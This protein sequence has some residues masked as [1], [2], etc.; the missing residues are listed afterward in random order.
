MSVD[1]DKE[2][3]EAAEERIKEQVKKSGV[4][5]C[6]GDQLT[7]ERFESCKRLKQG[8]T[9]CF[10]RYEFMPIFRIGMFHLREAFQIN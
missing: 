5:I 2:T 10:E 6:H 4:L 8:S 3:R 1:C 7:E 9:S